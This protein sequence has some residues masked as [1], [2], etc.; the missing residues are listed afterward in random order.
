MD[1]VKK[2]VALFRALLEACADAVI[3]SDAEGVIL[4]SNPAACHLFDY[5][6]SDLDGA[7]VDMLMPES[8]AR[9]HAGFMSRHLETGET[10]IIGKG[11]DVEGR[12]RDG[13][14]FPL[15]LSIGRTEIEGTI[16]FIAILHDL[17]RRRAT[18]K[19]LERSQRLDAIGQMTGGIAHD[20]NNLLTVVIG[21][22]ELLEMRGGD[23]KHQA[24]VRSALDSAEL[25]SDLV[26]RLMLFARQGHLNPKIADLGELCQETFAMLKRTI[27]AS[28][29]IRTYFAPDLHKVL[30]DPSQLQSALTNLAL[31][32]RD[33]MGEKGSLLIA[34]ENV[35]IDDD[36]MAQENSVA[37]GDYVRL[38]VS[39]TGEG[40][41]P[42]TQL[43]AFE[44]FYTTKSESGGTG[45]GLSMV[46]GFVRQSGGHVS[47]YSE[48]GHGTTFSLYFPF[49]E[50]SDLPPRKDRAST[51]AEIPRGA[52]E[53]VLVVEDNPLVRGFAVAR[54]REI[55]YRTRE[56]ENGD[57]AYALLTSGE[58]VDVVFS[59]LVMPGT[60]NGYDL[61]DRL[62]NEFPSIKV[63]L[64]S[65]YTSDVLSR[66]ATFARHDEILHKP[67]H[68]AELAQ[69]IHALLT[70]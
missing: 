9:E 58:P 43:H 37:K 41:S 46:Y 5:D 2:E 39:D 50:D 40:M 16:Y 69:R 59:D 64:T 11:R 12:R 45:L 67:Y 35:S 49:A 1:T 55:G 29:A 22:L 25:G 14:L 63:L 42:E 57:D 68:H 8:M 47:V 15:H 30:I 3:I 32:A 13:T 21:N 51:D 34:V 33:A 27:G 44:P 62:T 18:L 31:N 4:R 52:G 17:T 38:S 56:A 23:E 26:R 20:F 6:A 61:R 70:T 19:A 66:D 24:L 28:Y 7:P 48:P 60:L 54:L 36:Y 10:R 65:G 53:T